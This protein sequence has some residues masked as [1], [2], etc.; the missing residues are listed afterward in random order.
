MEGRDLRITPRVVKLSNAVANCRNRHLAGFGLT[1]CQVVALRLILLNPGISVSELMK[2]PAI[3][4]SV[5]S[6]IIA[7]PEKNGFVQK[8]TGE[9]DE[10]TGERRFYRLQ[11]RDFNKN[12]L[13]MR[14]KK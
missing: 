9:D 2:H 5:V 1:P 3:S 10:M 7:R 14:M 6:G 11:R 13:F 12:P 8:T 4:Q